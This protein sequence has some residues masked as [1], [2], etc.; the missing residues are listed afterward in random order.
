MKIITRVA[1]KV[2]LY[3]FND[4]EVISLNANSTSIGDPVELII[5]DCDLSNSL[6]FDQVE[7]MPEDWIGGKYCFNGQSWT[8]NDQY[9]PIEKQVSIGDN[10]V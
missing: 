4:N 2:A 1:T 7:N 10:E 6:V 9:K 5:S 3:A 8:L